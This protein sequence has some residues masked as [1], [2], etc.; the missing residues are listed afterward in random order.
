[1]LQNVCNE[2]VVTSYLQYCVYSI[3]FLLK[4]I[5]VHKFCEIFQGIFRQTL[6]KIGIVHYI[7]F[8]I[9][10][11]NDTIAVEYNKTTMTTSNTYNTQD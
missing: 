5:I 1:M 9:H 3:L 11:P 7:K 8:I 10:A 6:L 2:N 4:I